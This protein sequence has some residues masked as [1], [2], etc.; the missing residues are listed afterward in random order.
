MFNR[1]TYQFVVTAGGEEGA[2]AGPPDAVDAPQV[3]LH[4]GEQ[5]RDVLVGGGLG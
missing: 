2:R 5:L 1:L 3:V 4:A